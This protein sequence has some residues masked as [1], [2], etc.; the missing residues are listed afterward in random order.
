MT[1]ESASLKIS[2]L[3]GASSAVLQ[4]T[5][6]T[7]FSSSASLVVPVVSAIVGGLMSYAVLKT[8]VQ[9]MEQDVRDM[10][11]DMSEIYTLVRESMT[12]LAHLEG[13]VDASHH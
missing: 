12:K 1:V 5:P 7:G 2:A 10:R 6:S 8:T 4:Q 9:K 3:L 13:R 11:K